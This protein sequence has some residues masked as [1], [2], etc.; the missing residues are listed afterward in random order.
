MLKKQ[1][2]KTV[3]NKGAQRRFF[4]LMPMT[5][6]HAQPAACSGGNGLQHFRPHSFQHFSNVLFIECGDDVTSG[7]A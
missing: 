3:V 1:P 6:L 5:A 2:A 7:P 4:M